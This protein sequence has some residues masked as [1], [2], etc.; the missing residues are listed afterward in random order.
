[1]KQSRY[2]ILSMRGKGT[3]IKGLKMLLQS[4]L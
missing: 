3:N 2:K 4:D 1:M